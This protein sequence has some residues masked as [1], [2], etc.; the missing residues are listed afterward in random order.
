MTSRSGRAARGRV[1]VQTWRTAGSSVRH[2]PPARARLDLA[3]GRVPSR[4]ASANVVRYTSVSQP[5][6]KALATPSRAWSWAMAAV[7]ANVRQAGDT[8]WAATSAL[9]RSSGA[10][11]NRMASAGSRNPKAAGIAVED[12]AHV[13]PDVPPVLVGCLAVGAGRHPADLGRVARRVGGEPDRGDA[14]GP[15]GRIGYIGLVEVRL[16]ARRSAT[17]TRGRPGPGR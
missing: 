15:R 8:R 1:A 7:N 5:R 3:R 4:P 17:P 9:P 10:S 2:A 14:A 13:V 16:R 12:V 11:S 6:W